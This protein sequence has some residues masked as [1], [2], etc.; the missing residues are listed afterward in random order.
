MPGDVSVMGMDDLPQAAFYH[1]PLSSIHVPMHEIG[2][3]ALDLLLDA[4]NGNATP[5]R[6]IELAC[7]IVERHSTARARKQ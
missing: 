3:S 2:A 5:A 6:R 1:P 7:H 4:V